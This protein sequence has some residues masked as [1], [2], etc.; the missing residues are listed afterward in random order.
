M[1]VLK[2]KRTQSSLEY[3]RAFMELYEHCKQNTM[4]LPRRRHE[5]LA[6][7]IMEIMNR[8]YVHVMN[9]QFLP[10]RG[11]S[12]MEV[13]Y[14]EIS[15][16]LEILME[17]EKPIMVLWGISGDK[18][19][20]ELKHQKNSSRGYWAELTNRSIN[21][22]QALERSNPNHA[23]DAAPPNPVVYFT[24]KEIA[25]SR[26]LTLTRKILRITHTRYIRLP[27]EMRD[28]EMASLL[29][30][31]NDAFYHAVRGNKFIPRTKREYEK[32]REHI[33]KCI[34]CLN[35]MNRVMLG[36]FASEKLSEK[37]MAEWAETLADAL[38]ISYRVQ[39]SDKKRFEHLER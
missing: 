14:R 33:S 13:K 28:A 22:L 37:Q 6:K 2:N 23:E 15:K 16:A 4:H 10:V 12:Y 39:N 21:L 38:E 5:T 34:A 36:V 9:I 1:A 24:D 27:V 8:A 29:W 18:E 11:R 26:F 25:S 3:E 32:R 19:A 17:I 20:T 30:L 7:P 31:A 35:D